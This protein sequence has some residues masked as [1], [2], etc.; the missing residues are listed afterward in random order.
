M[1]ARDV[2][3]SRDVALVP[4]VLLADVDD[5]RLARLDPATAFAGVDLRDLGPHLLQELSIVRHRYRKYSFAPF[6]SV[7]WDERACQG[8]DHRRA[9][10]RRRCGNRRRS[11]AARYPH[12][13]LVQLE[14]G[15][16][17]ALSGQQA[18]ATRAWQ[19][20]ERAQ[21]DSPSAVRAQDLRHPGSPPGLPPFV[22]SF[23]RVTNAVE[24][25]L[26][27]GA[28]YQQGLRPV[29]AEREFAAA[30]KAAPNDPEALTAA[31]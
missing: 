8:L 1:T 17:L 4:L 11:H 10:R 20:A 31:A 16:A 27:R 28:A 21:P 30:A 14:L 26:L 22:P 6:A 29:S 24:S 5:D 15:L 3:G 25:L 7:A 13:A 2:D 9:R 19:A 18:D 12:S 23:T